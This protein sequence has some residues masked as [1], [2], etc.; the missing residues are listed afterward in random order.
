MKNRVTY[1]TG[2]RETGFVII[3]TLNNIG[4]KRS[5]SSNNNKISTPEWD[6]GSD[7]SDPNKNYSKDFLEDGDHN[8][9]TQTVRG[10]SPSRERIFI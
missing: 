7:F 2:R 8:M 6:N 5:N 3:W 10:V 4:G 1:N 9:V